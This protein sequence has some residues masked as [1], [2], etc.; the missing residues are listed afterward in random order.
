[1]FP[2]NFMANIMRD[3]R[4]AV[5]EAEESERKNVNV[6]ELFEK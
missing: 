4:K 6:K 3:T 1:M 5:F 2:K